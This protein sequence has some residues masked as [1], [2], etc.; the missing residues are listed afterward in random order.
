MLNSSFF[1]RVQQIVH[2]LCIAYLQEEVGH[3]GTFEKNSDFLTCLNTN[4]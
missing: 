4:K 2:A 3:L 1:K